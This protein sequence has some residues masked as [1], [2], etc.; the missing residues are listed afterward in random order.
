MEAKLDSKGKNINKEAY[1]ICFFF[2][3]AVCIR[4]EFFLLPKKIFSWHV[5]LMVH[6]TITTPRLLCLFYVPDFGGR[7]ATYTKKKDEEP[8]AQL[9]EKKIQVVYV[10]RLYSRPPTSKL[11]S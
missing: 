8:H 2:V 3:G 7:L 4:A 10:S 1:S 9:V 11:F 6:I 5:F